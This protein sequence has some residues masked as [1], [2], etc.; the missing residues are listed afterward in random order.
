MVNAARRASGW[1]PRAGRAVRVALASLLPLAGCQS[2]QPPPAVPA[3]PP[4]ASIAAL[5]R[6]PAERALIEGIRLYE[7]AAFPRA[8]AMLRQALEDGLAD[9]RDRA[10]AYKYVAFITCA[11]GRL[12]ECEASFARAFAA[13]PDFA[14]DEKEIGHPIWGPVY[15]RVAAQMRG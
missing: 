13:D 3:E 7:E 10:V 2:L 15:R 11:F 6:Q 12:E 4:T 1:P 5:F 8:E 9:R 14:L